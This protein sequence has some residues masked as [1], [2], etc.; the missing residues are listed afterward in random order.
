MSSANIKQRKGPSGPLNEEA[1]LGPAGGDL[2]GAYPDPQVV[3][4]TEEAGTG[5]RL[6]I[7]NIDEGTFLKRQG[8]EIV[9]VSNP[10]ATPT[11]PAGGDL[12]GTYP[13]PEVVAI[14]ETSGPTRLAIDGIGDGEVLVR[15]G[16]TVEGIS[17]AF[18]PGGTLIGD[19]NGPAGS[20]EVNAI[21]ETSGPTSLTIQSIADGQVLVRAGLNLQGVDPAS[22]P[23]GTLSGDANGPAGSN[24]V[25]SSTWNS[26][27]LSHG[28]VA[29]GELVIRSGGN[30]V[31]IAPASIPGG[32]LSGDAN[33][34]AGS[35]QVTSSTWNSVALSHGTV[36]DGELVIRSGG[37]LVGIAPGSLPVG[38][39]SGDVNGPAGSNEVNALTEASGP[40]SL[41]IGAIPDGSVAQRQGATFNGITPGTTGYVLTQTAGGPNW[42][43]SAGIPGS[44]AFRENFPY[45]LIQTNWNVGSNNSLYASPIFAGF[46]ASVSTIRVVITQTQTPAT[47]RAGVYVLDLTS[48][49]QYDLVSESAEVNIVG[50]GAYDVPLGSP[51]LLEAG[52][53]YYACVRITSQ[54]NWLVGNTGNWTGGVF[55]NTPQQNW[56]RDGVVSGALPDPI[57]N[58]Q[59]QSG[60]APWFGL[61]S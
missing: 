46:T 50:T 33:G 14:E 16:A 31:G 1:T 47:I 36:A 12:G 54:G 19:V 11:G 53:V 10:G 24:Q 32:T 5:D 17:P 34:P 4:V 25:T 22:L 58:A 57:L 15:S 13:D 39:L 20:N 55:A 59:T 44:G 35:N 7:G 30:L 6:P 21:T 49:V 26:V 40:T 18:L 43:P 61:I 2:D 23:S 41:T 52:K 3:A 9:G 48:G 60:F 28:A 45:C 56:R 51:A 8:N 29:D 38:S 37:N 27:A 42:E